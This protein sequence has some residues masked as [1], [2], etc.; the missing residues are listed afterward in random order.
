MKKIIKFDD[1]EI[2]KYKFYQNKSPI[3]IK[4]IHINQ[5]VVSNN[6]PFV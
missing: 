2:E 3:L 5:M 6:L 1:T 4:D